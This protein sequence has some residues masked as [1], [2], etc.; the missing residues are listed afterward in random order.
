MGF[1]DAAW[2]DPAHPSWLRLSAD[3]QP[4]AAQVSGRSDLVVSVRPDIGLASAADYLDEDSEIR[5]EAG[6]A[7]NR[8]TDDP[9]RLDLSR[10]EG[11]SARAALAGLVTLQ[12]GIAGWAPRVPEGT[13]DHIRRWAT[14]LVGVAGSAAI[15]RSRPA[16]RT[17]LRVAL[18]VS[19][20][21]A[22]PDEPIPTIG[23]VVWFTAQ[24][25]AG[26]L[27]VGETE[28]VRNR[29]LMLVGPRRLPE[30]RE[31]LAAAAELGTDSGN[32]LIRL[33]T[34]LS[35]QL[36]TEEVGDPGA[37][38]GHEL[39]QPSHQQPEP[40]S[41]IREIARTSQALLHPPTTAHHRAQERLHEADLRELST[42]AAQRVFARR[43]SE[44]GGKTAGAEL[45]SAARTLAGTLRAV[46]FRSPELRR[47][48]S[49]TPPGRTRMAELMR[50]DAQIAARTPVTA[51]P[52]RQLRR[53][54]TEEPELRVG[55]SWDISASRMDVHAEM[56][57]VAWAVAWAA[58][59]IEGLVAAAAWN[60]RCVPII[61]PGRVPEVVPQVPCAGRSTGGPESLRAL[62]GALDL[63]DADGLRLMLIASDGRLP[64]RRHLQAEVDRLH[65]KGV[66]VL[67]LAP[68]D[69]WW[70]PQGATLLAAPRGAA[71]AA[72]AA[73]L[74][75]AL[76][77]A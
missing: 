61:H 42:R 33:S 60:D 18:P 77:A 75:T 39:E 57:E 15:V 7:L 37:T 45:R 70:A 12:S 27:T 54:I 19:C 36:D 1:A 23:P 68:A 26:V 41:E 10:A 58:R 51:L 14:L 28:R 9:R 24:V 74:S 59:R 13:P 47:V 48:T 69:L 72:L 43:T 55:L 52:W 50:R 32:E 35:D 2:Q 56:C 71:L 25:A 76:K 8:T 64:N 53:H 66:Q 63:A 3:L 22:R 29:L 67:W 62:D 38:S 44:T 6:L 21:I 4:L 17:W 34:A 11:R 40:L 30:I 16:Y 49:A 65:D 20:P 31:L 73:H 46:R 5:I